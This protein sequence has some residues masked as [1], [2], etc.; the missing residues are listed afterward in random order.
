MKVQRETKDY[1]NPPVAG[2]RPRGGPPLAGAGR[3]GSPRPGRRWYSGTVGPGC[4]P[5]CWGERDLA[6]STSAVIP[7]LVGMIIIYRNF[8]FQ[9]YLDRIQ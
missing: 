5:G 3:L 7:L 8:H 2:A 4:L 9:G 1:L 6:R